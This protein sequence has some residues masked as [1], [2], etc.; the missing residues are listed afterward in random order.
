VSLTSKDDWVEIRTELDSHADTCCVSDKTALVIHDFDQPVNVHSYSDLI[1]TLRCKTVSAVLWYDHPETGDTYMLVIHQAVL[2]PKLKANLLCPM[3]LH[4]FDIR[5]NDK[6]K[7]MALTP[8]DDHHAIVIPAVEEKDSLCIP[9]LIHGVTS[10]FPSRKP[11]TE[12]YESCDEGFRIELTNE[13]VEWDP[14]AKRFAE[15]EES[16][17]DDRG[18]LREHN[19]NSLTQTRRTV[20]ALHTFDQGGQPD[21]DLLDALV[22]NVRVR[23]TVTAREKRNIAMATSA[24]GR[25]IGAKT[26]AKNWCIGLKQAERTIE[27]TT[28]RGLHTI[29]HPML[30]RKGSGRAIDNSNT[31]NYCMRCSLTL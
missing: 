19:D 7:H 11:M 3:Q 8:T 12:E 23:S 31:G 29:L 13:N 16:M 4:D 1:G 22:S 18:R 17:L 6:P 9:L 28:Q 30:S 25:M 2:I 27:A 10:Y 21:L 14:Q 24:R 15:Q 5:V 26:L 20:A